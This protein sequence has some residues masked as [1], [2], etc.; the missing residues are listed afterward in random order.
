MAGKK[1]TITCKVCE[2]EHS[3]TICT[4]YSGVR[5]VEPAP[6]GK[7]G[8]TQVKK[9]VAMLSAPSQQKA[10]APAI[11]DTSEPLPIIDVIAEP[12]EKSAPV[13]KLAKPRASKR[14]TKLAG[15]GRPKVHG[16]RAERQAAYRARKAKGTIEK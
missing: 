1:A 2:G 9:A 16:S 14:V 4:K 13:T 7:I 3:G 11:I 5:V 6:K 10:A 15:A 8:V 12:V